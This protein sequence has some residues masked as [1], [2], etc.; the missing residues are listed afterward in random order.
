[1]TPYPLCT[2]ISGDDVALRR[3]GSVALDRSGPEWPAM[4]IALM[5]LGLGLYILAV[6]Y[7]GDFP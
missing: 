1:M 5:L 4:S 6:L 2:G 7:D 3:L